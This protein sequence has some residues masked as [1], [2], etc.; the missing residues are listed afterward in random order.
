MTPRGARRAATQRLAL[1]LNDDFFEP[2]TLRASRGPI[3]YFRF[4][5]D[6]Y[7]PDDLTTR[8]DSSEGSASD[9]D[10]YV[11]FAHED[12]PDS[13]RPALA[14]SRSC[15]QLSSS[16]RSIALASP[17]CALPPLPL[18]GAS[19]RQ[20]SGWSTRRPLPGRSATRSRCARSRSSRRTQPAP[21]ASVSLR[22]RRPLLRLFL[23]C[24]L[25]GLLDRLDE[26]LRGFARPCSRTP[27]R[28]TRVR[29]ELLQ[30]FAA[31]TRDVLRLVLDLVRRALRSFLPASHAVS[32]STRTEQRFTLLL[33]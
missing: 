17:S 25:R 28:R 15:V 7:E 32:P 22:R 26:F 10:V 11:Y 13:V 4:H 19:G 14:I 29:R 6:C 33:R 27:S 24:A 31:F 1:C 5:R 21:I 12:N 30:R 8:A 16:L 2:S 9:V 3:A 18:V 20:I 23:A